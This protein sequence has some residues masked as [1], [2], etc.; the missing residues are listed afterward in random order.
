MTTQT[1]FS[2]KKTKTQ[3]RRFFNSR[4][5]KFKLKTGWPLFIVFIFVFILS[6]GVPS[7][8]FITE[9]I[10]RYY[11][12]ELRDKAVNFLYGI[13]IV[14]VVISMF[15]GLLCGLTTMKYT[16]NKV[17]VNFYHSLPVRREALFITS[18]LQSFV[19]YVSAFAAG[20]LMVFATFALRLGSMTEYFIRPILLTFEYGVLFFFLIYAMTLFAA[21]LTGT[22]FMRII[23]AAYVIFLPLGMYS[24]FVATL[25][26]G[27]IHNKIIN[28][29][30]Y[31]SY[32]P[33]IFLCPPFRFLNLILEN[34]SG[35]MTF[36]GAISKDVVIVF[37][38]AVVFYGLAFLLYCLRASE[39][40]S[41]PV[42]W[43]PA[44][45]VFKYA[46]IFM[47]GTLFALMF[48]GMFESVPWMIFGVIIGSVILFMLTN[49][50]ISKSAR[51]IF[52]GL[53]GFAAYMAVMAAITA[54]FYCDV[55]GMFATVPDGALVKRVELNVD[56]S[57]E[58][59]YGG[60][61]ACKVTNL[62]KKTME[63]SE[64][65]D[66]GIY[67]GSNEV[68]LVEI[69]TE[70][71]ANTEDVVYN[72]GY[73]YAG[74]EYQS[75]TVEAVLHTKIGIPYAIRIY[76]DCEA[77]HE[78]VKYLYDTGKA[79][80]KIPPA[81]QFDSGYIDVFLDEYYESDIADHDNINE[82]V[83]LAEMLSDP[84]G[85]KADSPIVGQISLYRK[86]DAS[87]NIFY[88]PNGRYCNYMI[89]ANDVDV[90]N[91]IMED[92][93][94]SFESGDHVIDYYIDTIGLQEICVVDNEKNERITLREEDTLREF[95]K[96]L[97]SLTYY[98]GDF[99][100]CEN[101]H[102]YNVFL[103]LV[104]DTD[105]Y[106]GCMHFRRGAVPERVTEL[107]GG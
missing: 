20:L 24:L 66:G 94:G 33:V 52:K 81:D 91:E 5:F 86:Y 101:E 30:Y 105:Y 42:I 99:P 16:T 8:S 104:D 103:K 40:A 49:G 70:E 12:N 55:F 15:G 13:G 50:I 23:A 26:T 41:Q 53:G 80:T 79:D 62:L 29:G 65:S 6:M 98:Y 43:K 93:D 9:H 1:S 7:V 82:L 72:G 28:T 75:V 78:L 60:D 22:G 36:A 32:Q 76:P 83:R 63:K 35:G 4:F 37:V 38:T 18:T 54:V 48:D 45:F 44:R 14:N 106:G 25:G 87:S 57:L 47:G 107:F 90:L 88:S 17:A 68:P 21:S 77:A 39:S 84:F 59:E 3:N 34:V 19:Y 69:Y 96:A 89:H 46:S 61:F 10:S 51:E 2:D 71:K 56:Y 85:L 102:R 27:G 100:L 92:F 73:A 97:W 74:W 95:T 11:G 67:Y 58:A 31:F 64:F